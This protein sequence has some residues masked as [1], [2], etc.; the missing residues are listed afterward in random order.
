MVGSTEKP[1]LKNFDKPDEVKTFPNGKMELIKVGGASV[2]R[3]TF[4]PGWK[5]SISNQPFFNTKSHEVA[6][7]GYQLSGRLMVSMDDGTQLE[8]VAGDVTSIPKGHDGWVI[9]DEPV[10]MLDFQGLIDLAN[11]K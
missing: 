10:V 5:W 1:E 3:F 9:G 6:H 8:C 7:F 11:Q 2:L 4:N